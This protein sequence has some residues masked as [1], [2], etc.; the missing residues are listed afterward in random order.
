[1][2]LGGTINGSVT[3]RSSYFSFYMEWSATQSISGNYSDVTVKTYWKTDNTSYTFDTVA[4]RSASITINGTTTPITQRFVCNPWPSGGIYSIQ[5]ATTRV[6]H[7]NDGTKSITIS[8]RANGHASSYGPSNSTA[9]SGDCTASGTIN[10]DTIP[11]ASSFGTVTGTT[12]KEDS[13]V[14]VNITRNSDSFTHT[15][16]YRVNSSG[17]WHEVTGVSDSK[18]LNIGS[19]ILS[20]LPSATTGTLNLCISTYNG[21]TQIGDDV[22][23]NFTV[24]V[25]DSVKP[26]VGTISFDPFNITTKDGT[27]R[28]ILV[29]NQNK[30]RIKLSGSTAGAGSTIESYTFS[31]PGIPET[32]QSSSNSNYDYDSIG[33]ISET[34]ELTYTVKIKDTRGRTSSKTA[35]LTCYDHNPPSFSSFSA[36]RCDAN[37]T[38]SEN[39]TYIKYSF[40]T[41]YASV[42]STNKIYD[43]QIWY[44]KGNG[45]WVTC[46]SA[47]SNTTTTS[48]SDLIKNTS[49]SNVTFGLDD[50]YVVC[51]K[52]TDNYGSYAD[53]ANITVFGQ[54]RIMN[55]RP[56][57][58]GIAFGKV[59]ESDNLL[60][61]KWPVKTLDNLTV[62]TNLT[63]GNSTQSTVPTGGIHVH[64]LRSATINPNSFGPYNV[65]F[66]T[67]KMS[68]NR[69]YNIL[70]MHSDT[71]WA[72]W[73]LAGNGNN[74]LKDDTLKYRQG[75][76][77]SWGNWQTVLTKEN[78][79]THFTIPSVSGY[80]P[81]SGG[82]LTG[83]L[84]LNGQQFYPDCGL[85]CGN[86]DIINANGIFFGD[87]A[88]SGGEG[89]NFWHNSSSDGWD[90]VY[91]ADGKLK[92]HPNRATNGALDGYTVLNSSNVKCGTCTLSSSGSGTTV[93]FNG[94]AFPS[95]PTVML[96]PLTTSSGVI[97]GKVRSV[98]TTGFT[99]I[100][101]GTAVTSAA[102][103][104]F[105]ICI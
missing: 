34:G 9:S 51:A 103:A 50:T 80:L 47:L 6:S 28:D 30:L 1:M 86:S 96:T 52:V 36:Y 23:K 99:A 39:G 58:S 8:A 49:N 41:N 63:V 56:G 97:P 53:S 38:A 40:G 87:K 68:D 105:A 61:I 65:N 44:K 85:N 26:S 11:R 17:G 66:Y 12:V 31:G 74:N 92:F 79:S 10:L 19:W 22:Y 102:F 60:E 46:K 13:S 95:A 101:G 98:S 43:V 27:S 33:T 70:H 5:T 54:P 84:T 48:A 72:A 91:A 100:I 104:Y 82:T 25:D 93:S 15:L 3:N 45:G 78:F 89:I 18:T 83:A 29:K 64:D 7:N 81:K 32:V 76:G 20:Q 2:A 57:G 75:V 71:G 67:N 24:S 62:G 94:A 42:N 59:A 88:D 55:I 69:W 14:T 4:S 16:W 73:E 90:T 21:T 37:G 35:K 77:N